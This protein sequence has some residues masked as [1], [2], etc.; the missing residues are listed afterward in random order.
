[1]NKGTFAE[2]QPELKHYLQKEI[3]VK[4]QAKRTVKGIL[5]GYDQYMNLVLDN[6]F[7][8][9]TNQQIPIGQILIRGNAVLSLQL[10]NQSSN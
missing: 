3:I 10:V 4:I 1:M 5:S 7:D 6:A 8:V 9:T 2:S